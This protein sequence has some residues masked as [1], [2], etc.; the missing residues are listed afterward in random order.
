MR[1][2]RSVVVACLAL[3]FVGACGAPEASPA[4]TASSRLALVA[5]SVPSAAYVP[6]IAELPPGWVV[7]D[8]ETDD[9]GT[10]LSLRSDRADRAVVVELVPACD[11]RTA[12]PIES[13]QEGVRS[14]SDVARVDP[15]VA[16]RFVDVFPGGCVV[17]GYDFARGPHVALVTDLR[18]I[19]GLVS[20]REVRQRV[21]DEI[22][23]KLDG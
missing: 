19:V 7:A 17:T 21:E 1:R 2:A 8:V 12:T 16:G 14:F 4:C 3:G 11:V 6:C 15:R 13:A 18:R 5:Q 23:V 20:R 10:Q 9:D 22:G